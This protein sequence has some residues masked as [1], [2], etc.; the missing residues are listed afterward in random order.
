MRYDDIG[1]VPV[2]C[3]TVRYGMQVKDDSRVRH[4]TGQQEFVILHRISLVTRFGAFAWFLPGFLEIGYFFV[5]FLV[6]L[7][8]L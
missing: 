6:T 7:I 1:T 8:Y 3:G 4:R 5:V 2:P